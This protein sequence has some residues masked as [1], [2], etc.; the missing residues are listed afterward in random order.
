MRGLGSGI[1]RRDD[2]LEF[3]RVGARFRRKF[4]DQRVETAEVTDVAEV[5]SVPHVRFEFTVQRPGLM[6]YDGGPRMMSLKRFCR[7]YVGGLS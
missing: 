5:L 3:V 1:F 2:A 7:D 4:S 6:P